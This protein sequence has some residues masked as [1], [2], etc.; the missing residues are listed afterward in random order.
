M[1]ASIVGLITAAA[2]GITNALV[3]GVTM[4]WPTR[5][6]YAAFVLALVLGVLVTLLAAIA[7]LPATATLDR[8]AFAQIVLAGL[9]SGLAAAG[10]GVSQ[11]SAEAKRKE[12]GATTEPDP[13]TPQSS[14]GIRH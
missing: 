7:Y 4:F 8:Q 10:I 14:N 2:S 11:A 5:P 6:K 13:V 1:D 12:V 3:S 9:G